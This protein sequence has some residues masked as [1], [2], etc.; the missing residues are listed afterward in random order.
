M[1]RTCPSF[2]RR[3]ADTSRG[4]NARLIAPILH[5]RCQSN[6]DART[7]A[8]PGYLRVMERFR[9]PERSPSVARAIADHLR[10]LR[11]GR[12]IVA[13]NESQQPS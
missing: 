6:S 12:G 10:A 13:H 11:L 8:R 9:D 5:N 3:V 1:V 7:R 4:A 2:S